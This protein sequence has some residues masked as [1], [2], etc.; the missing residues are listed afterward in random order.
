MN[1][2][3]FSAYTDMQTTQQ[4]FGKEKGRLAYHLVQ[5]FEPGE[6]T[7]EQAM[8]IGQMFADRYL[9]NRYEALLAVHTDHDHLH[10]HMIWN[11]VSYMDGKKYHAQR[12]QYLDGIRALSDE[13]CR[14][15]GLSV[16]EPA[17][18]EAN[19]AK[20]QHYAAWK[21]EQ[22]NR[23]S[24]R[25]L[26]KEDIEQILA[27]PH[28]MTLSQFDNELKNRGYEIKHG[29]FLAVRLSGQE[30]FVRLK[31]IGADYSEDAIRQ[32]LIVKSRRLPAFEPVTGRKSGHTVQHRPPV[33]C[34]GFMATYW[35]YVYR[36]YQ[37]RYQPRNRKVSPMMRAEIFQLEKI[38]SDFR[39]IRREHIENIDQL[40]IFRGT[41]TEEMRV[42]QL[43]RQTLRKEATQHPVNEMELFM[44]MDAIAVKLKEKRRELRQL[45]RIENKSTQIAARLKAV[46]EAEKESVQPV[47]HRLRFEK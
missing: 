33:R 16:I 27:D 10:C 3:A 39:L 43:Q 6:V 42:L 36:I 29:K 32:R 9:L 24:H 45:D 18:T 23:P 4:Q 30:R 21:A 26:L 7:A 28:I 34:T 22:E 19:A 5:S 31:S 47:D 12:G 46:E 17:D 8:S 2:S 15:Q 38:I 41:I 11:A 44:Q 13:L 14:E 20:G 35:W 40:N 1:C 25:S 37:V